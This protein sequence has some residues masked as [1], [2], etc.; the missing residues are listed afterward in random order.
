MLTFFKVGSDSTYVLIHSIVAVSSI[1]TQQDGAEREGHCL[2]GYFQLYP[3]ENIQNPELSQ[4]N[5]V[6]KPG[7]EYRGQSKQ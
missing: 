2:I 4:D 3:V 1:R 6:F 7:Y 5:Y